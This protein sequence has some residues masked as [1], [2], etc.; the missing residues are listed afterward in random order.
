MHDRARALVHMQA[1]PLQYQQHHMLW[2]LLY[3]LDSFVSSRPFGR[4]MG[5]IYRAFPPSFWRPL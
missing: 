2:L 4:K 1:H 3:L 5:R